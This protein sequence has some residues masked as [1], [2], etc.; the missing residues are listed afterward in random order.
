MPAHTPPDATRNSDSP[1]FIP[2]GISRVS[3]QH[4]DTATVSDA[5]AYRSGLTLRPS[6]PLVI[7]RKSGISPNKICLSH[8]V[9]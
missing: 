8:T 3:V 9:V 5:Y 4:D 6:I 1:E 7:L 2:P